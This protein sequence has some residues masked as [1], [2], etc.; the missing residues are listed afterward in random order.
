LAGT[1]PQ[2]IESVVTHILEEELRYRSGTPICS[3]WESG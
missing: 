3:E 1:N 2:V